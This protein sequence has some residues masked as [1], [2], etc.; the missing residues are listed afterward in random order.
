MKSQNIMSEGQEPNLILYPTRLKTL[1]GLAASL[2]AV[3]AGILMVSSGDVWHTGIGIVCS[4]FFGLGSLMYLVSLVHPFPVLVVNEEGIQQC[5]L[6]WN[7]FVAWEDI[8]AIISLKGRYASL[9]VYLSESGKET[10]SAR[11]PRRWRFSRLFGE[12]PAISLPQLLLPISAQQV[13]EALQKAH[14]QQIED[15]N[16]TIR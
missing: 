15:N 5:G 12:M 6:L 7:V 2:A 8:A 16:I 9:S 10:F 14:R 3:A 13:L 1:L 11:Y 4:G